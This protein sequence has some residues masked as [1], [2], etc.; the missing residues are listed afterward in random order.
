MVLQEIKQWRCIGFII[1]PM[2]WRMKMTDTL[3]VDDIDNDIHLDDDDETGKFYLFWNP[4]GTDDRVYS[5]SSTLENI[6]ISHDRS[7]KNKTKVLVLGE[8]IEAVHPIVGPLLV[9]KVM[10]HQIMFVG[11]MTLHV[12]EKN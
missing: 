2:D 8:P 1:C 9:S 5:F 11:F 6:G 3:L 7:L 10:A 12:I 4:D